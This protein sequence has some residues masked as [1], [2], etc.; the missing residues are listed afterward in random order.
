[1]QINTPPR[2]SDRIMP[3]VLLEE[4][5]PRDQSRDS[6]A[7][8]NR[9]KCTDSES[10]ET[11]YVNIENAMSL[12]RGKRGDTI[13]AF[14]GDKNDYV[15]VKES[16]EELLGPRPAAPS[17]AHAT[18]LLPSTITQTENVSGKIGKLALGEGDL[19]HRVLG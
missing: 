7:M 4:C 15:A 19:R 10:S 5:R 6:Q 9:A 11:V 13:I 14:P 3:M 12:V 16:P 2:A 18:Q 17:P 8:T 1:M